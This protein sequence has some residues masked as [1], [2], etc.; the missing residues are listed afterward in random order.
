MS[1]NLRNYVPSGPEIYYRSPCHQA[2]VKGWGFI[3]VTFVAWGYKNP[4]ALIAR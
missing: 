2:V 3:M 4:Q 1:L